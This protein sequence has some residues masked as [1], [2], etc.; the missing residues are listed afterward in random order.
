MS[1]AS[2]DNVSELGGASATPDEDPFFCL[3]EDDSLITEVNITTDRLLTSATS[4]I[5][6][7]LLVIGYAHH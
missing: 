4:H 3:L 6:D 2:F 5:H 7:V 1:F